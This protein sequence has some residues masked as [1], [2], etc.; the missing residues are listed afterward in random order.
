MNH[1]AGTCRLGDPDDP[2]AVVDLRLRVI[3]VPQLAQTQPSPQLAK[4]TSPYLSWLKLNPRLSW[5]KPSTRLSWIKPSTRLSWIK[6][7]TRLSWSNPRRVWAAVIVVAAHV[8][9]DRGC[10]D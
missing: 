5:I 9:P 3:G 2:H 8:S 10:P 4:Q 1:L 7:S 6:P